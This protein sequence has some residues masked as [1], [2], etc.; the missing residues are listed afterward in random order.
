MTPRWILLTACVLTTA[1]CTQGTA[2][3][4]LSTAA[5]SA[6]AFA[7]PSTQTPSGSPTP[8]LTPTETRPTELSLEEAG[9]RYL[10]VV[11][12]GNAWRD[13]YRQVAQK[14]EPDFVSDGDPLSAKT[15]RAASK[16]ATSLTQTAQLLV[17]ADQVWPPSIRKEIELVAAGIYEDASWYQNVAS[18]NTWGDVPNFPKGAKADRAAS[19]VRLT[20]GLPPRGDAGVNGCPKVQ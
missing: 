19:T 17:Q 10:D 20:L 3:P 15:K 9:Q 4:G 2:S 6:S 13:K 8:T 1:A 16:A 11:C 7:S 12:P 5:S 18:A 14:F